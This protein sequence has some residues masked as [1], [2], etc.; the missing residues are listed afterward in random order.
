MTLNKTGRV[1]V[2]GGGIAGIQSSLD[3]A[4]SGFHVYLV[5]SSP[6]IGGLMAR[7]DKTFPTNDCAMCILSPKLVEC[8]R[9]LNID[10]LSYSEVE[11]I[12]GQ[13][14]QFTVTVRKKARYIDVSKCTGCS[15]CVGVCPVDRPNEFEN[16]LNTRKA[17]FRP[18]P[19]AFPN[20]FTI[21]KK[22][23][24]NCQAA[25]PLEQK[26]QGYIALVKNQ[27]YEDA[28]R[29]VRLDN[30]FPAIC[31]RACHHPCMEKCQRGVLDEPLGIP[32][33][34]RFLS[35]YETA[36][37]I[38]VLPE[39]ESAKPQKVAIVGAGP[40]GLSCAYF[41]A[42]KGYSVEIFEAKDQ[43]GG[44]MVY[45]IPAYRLPREVVSR[46][47]ETI[48]SLGVAIHYGKKWGKDFTLDQLFE[49]NFQAVYLACGAWKGMKVGVDGE[50]HPRI[51]DG[52]FY[53]DQANSGEE[54]PQAQEIVI[55]GGGNVA[56]DCARTA[57]RRGAKKVSIYYRRSREEMPAR[58]EEIEDAQ[59]EGIE[60]FYCA[61]PRAFAERDGSLYMETF[62][63]RLCAP[64]ESGRRR[65]EV[66]PGS[67]YE[68]AADL[69]ILA[70]GQEVD[71]PDE[72]LEKTR[73]GTIKTNEKLETSRQDVYAGGDLVM[74][75]STL[76][77]SIA[78][79]KRAAQVIDAKFTER[80]FSV[81]RR[82][83]APLSIPWNTIRKNRTH[84][85]KVP[86]L[87]RVND[88]REVELGYTEK[89]VLEEAT[90]C[91]SC[92]GCSE[93]MQ[94]VFSCQR[95]AIDHTMKD[96][97]EKIEVGAII[98][99]SGA[100]AFNTTE[101]YRELGYRKFSNVITSLD[102]ERILNASGPFSGKVQR[103]SDRKTPKKIA[104]VQCIGSRD[105]ERGKSYCSSVCCMY[106]I[107]EALVAK[108]HLAIEHHEEQP[109]EA[110]C[111]C[112]TDFPNGEGT[113]NQ[114]LTL[115]SSSEE[116]SATVFMIDM[117]AYGK[118]FEKYYQRAKREG[119][120]FIRGKVDRVKE[121]DNG[122]LEVAFVD[123]QGNF[124]KENFELLILSVGLQVEPEKLAQLEKLGLSIRPEGFLSTDPTN[125][126][127]TT[128]QGIWVCGTL[129]GP[130]DIP[131]TV[132]EASAAS[133]DVA[134]FLH[135][136][137]FT[138]VKEKAYPQ[139]RDVSSEPLRIGVFIC[140]CGINIGGVVEVP[141][142]VEWAK[143]L[144]GVVYAEENLY[145]CSQDTQE[146]I[147]EKI[148]E[149]NLNRII[150]ASCSPRTHE[151]LFRETLKEAGLNP[152]LFEMANIRDQC[153]WVH[154]Q[155]PDDA[156]DKSRDLVSM[157]VAKATLLEPLTPM[158]LPLEK[159]LLVLGG[160][161]SGMTAAL[162]AAHQG[163]KV[164]L[165][166]KE[167]KLGGNLQGFQKKINIEGTQL[168]E[169]L[170]SMK[171]QI[172]NHPNIEVYL[173]AQVKEVNGFVGNFE[174][175]IL[176][177]GV[178]IPVKHGGVIVATGAHQ[179]QP[180][181]FL[182]QKDHRVLTQT[183]LEKQIDQ[184]DFS[185]VTS[186]VMIQCVGS[187]SD[188]HPWCSKICCGTAIKNALTIKE[189]SPDTEV[190]ILYRDLRSY[191]LQEK[192]YREAR[193]RGVVFVRFED[194][195]PPEVVQQ[196]SLLQVKVNSSVFQESVTL[197]AGLVVLSA[198]IVPLETNV[199]I[200][201]MLKVPLNQDGFFLEAHVKL[202][203]VDFATD[204]VYVCG[205]AHGPKSALESML[206]A[207]ACVARAMNILSKDQIQ[208][209]AQIAY[210]LKERCTACG[211]CE[212][213][214]AYKAVKINQEKK[215]AEVNAALCKGCGLCSAT[216][217][218]TAIKVQGFAPEQ[219]ISEVEYLL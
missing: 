24:A 122:D 143:S 126:I 219:L 120:R 35:D 29:T 2:V 147:K 32:S 77:E 48:L 144:P 54:L 129:A 90:R 56:I 178:E 218:S 76:V 199:A 154:Q 10:I 198:G 108:E 50:N 7:L 194:D 62:V 214:C 190:Y 14:G 188:D 182:Y 162:E 170:N 3:L 160:G 174:S 99:S 150:V 206:Q 51:M 181:E 28:L 192:Y 83:P 8:G 208:S 106:A 23:T 40:S 193:N 136:A 92:G 213:V 138:Q 163:L 47:I 201:K 86:V 158:L 46:D 65:P 49:Q 88:F 70:I 145:T 58:D 189:K 130:K 135:S 204:G 97:R 191:G 79:G 45:G 12:E 168:T 64:D 212:K 159:S 203:P 34:K 27:R 22:G 156:T 183:E 141:K 196:G 179:Y 71:I 98:F 39:P 211:D 134:G 67:G 93:C 87:K 140:R 187:R 131:D 113:T 151:P 197:P 173:N 74:G 57:L 9:H 33:I 114:N 117:R 38:K 133:C 69:F 17:T 68:V 13:P 139:Q 123:N 95:N 209:E 20:A 60:F 207:K 75:P 127:Q 16:F 205:L 116:F 217:K 184:D 41:L 66:I 110:G 63:M 128:R 81:E 124:Q 25:C 100:E 84:M 176:Q 148:L 80:E 6:T 164:F 155:S 118:D 36:H 185:T 115:A 132:M 152:Y 121:L 53:L 37:Q 210:V 78:H 42:L 15:D 101:K 195:D 72:G 73:R 167:A 215:I 149:L 52:L 103:P 11:E 146:R 142:V 157:A 91:L 44:M 112:G 19:Q 166:E 202:R 4:N 89:E 180:Q 94:C 18:F 216:C 59:E 175:T 55:V 119:I 43:P 1:M 85:S 31:G 200:G 137:R 111:S 109:V 153:S 96:T 104:F 30:P 82:R 172:T 61:S 102:F 107:K 161:L 177:A 21:E 169:L 26:A 165:V 186:V 125:P 5:E 105:P 171:D